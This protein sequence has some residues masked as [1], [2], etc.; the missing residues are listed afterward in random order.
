M[1]KIILT[2]D[3]IRIGY[4]A[5]VKEKLA[6]R[7]EVLCERCAG[8]MITGHTA[9]FA[10]CAFKPAGRFTKGK[11]AC[12]RLTGVDREKGILIGAEETV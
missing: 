12:I 9:N 1:K 7:A 11:T 8:G 4:D 2:G 3:S 5:Y 6:G 10:E